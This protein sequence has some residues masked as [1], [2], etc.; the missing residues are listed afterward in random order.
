MRCICY[1]KH[2]HPKRSNQAVGH[3][4]I[5]AH[6]TFR[7]SLE[8]RISK[9]HEHKRLDLVRFPLKVLWTAVRHKIH[10]VL[11]RILL[12]CHMLGFT[13]R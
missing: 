5:L 10:Y 9:T 13:G 1:R 6:K 8:R 12:L 3:G 7:A 2:L 11:W 4:I